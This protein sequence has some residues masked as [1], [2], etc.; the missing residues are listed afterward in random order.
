MT[1]PLVFRRETHLRA[2]KI[3]LVVGTI[4]AAINHGDAILEASMTTTAWVKVLLT[5]CVPYG[6]SWYS[7]VRPSV[8]PPLRVDTRFRA[9]VTGYPNMPHHTRQGVVI[10]ARPM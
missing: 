7:A 10:G 8:E 9:W 3:A 2:L 5:F 4:L 1:S 6:V